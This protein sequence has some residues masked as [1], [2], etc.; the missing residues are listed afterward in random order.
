MTTRWTGWDV[1]A[2]R[3]VVEVLESTEALDGRARCLSLLALAGRGFRPPGLITVEPHDVVV[4][5]RWSGAPLRR[6]WSVEYRQ[7]AETA[8]EGVRPHAIYLLGVD[9]PP[10]ATGEELEAFNDFY[11]E[12]HLRE[13]AERRGAL[14]AVRHERVRE[15]VAPPKGVPRYLAVYEVDEAGAARRRHEGPPY[16]KG[17]DVWQRH[18]TP[19]RLWYRVVLPTGA[20]G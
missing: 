10:G 14:R 17:P 16:S 5:E 18:T 7:I 13:V 6:L 2:G 11:T 9:P 15:L 19:W 8:P 3:D 4:T 1:A 12:V 20:R